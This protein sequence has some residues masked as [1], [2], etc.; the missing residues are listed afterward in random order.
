PYSLISPGFYMDRSEITL[1]QWRR[2]YDWAI[3]HGYRFDN[4]GKGKGA[5]H[6][7]HTVNWY[8]C[9]KWCNAR[10]EMEGLK[11]VY[12][13]RGHVLREDSVKGLASPDVVAFGSNDGYRLPS[14]DQ[15]DYAARGGVSSTLFPWGNEITRANANVLGH[16][17]TPKWFDKVSRGDPASD[18]LFEYDP[19]F[20]DGGMPFTCPAETFPPNGY[21]LTEMQGNVN[22]WLNDTSFWA[23]HQ[24]GAAYGGSWANGAEDC[25]LG[26]LFP[27]ERRWANDTIG[28]RTVLPAG[29][30]LPFTLIGGEP[31]EAVHPD[32]DERTDPVIFDP[33]GW[34]RRVPSNDLF[35]LVREGRQ[36]ERL[37]SG[38]DETPRDAG[39]KV[40]QEDVVPPASNGAGDSGDAP[41]T[42]P[43][44]DG[45]RPKVQS[46]A[47]PPERTGFHVKRASAANA[48]LMVY[49]DKGDA[50]ITP[51]SNFSFGFMHLGLENRT[52]YHVAV[53]V[54]RVFYSIGTS[55]DVVFT[56]IPP[57]GR[58]K[59]DE[60]MALLGDNVEQD[61]L[62]AP[63]LFPALILAVGSDG[64]LVD[65]YET[66]DCPSVGYL[67]D[68]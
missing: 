45:K 50:T 31:P 13:F 29:D 10:S 60:P 6:P 34:R 58:K 28:F 36:K 67:K 39:P 46:P 1:N 20:R 44:A 42:L 19:H 49:L 23:I 35:A 32:A 51:N 22:E 55:C 48:D 27:K 52:K 53:C 61:F 14:R 12:Y 2:V 26:I 3:M 62:A 11:P 17:G 63:F 47:A 30:A 16:K 5:H 7:V 37:A 56:D 15:W 21:G 33:Y 59:S 9:A 8:D 4:E 40:I 66:P 65:L 18:P 54:V 38:A 64:K 25:L 41:A 57:G 68:Y 43:A 24:E